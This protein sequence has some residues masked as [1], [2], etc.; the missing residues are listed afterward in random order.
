M[1]NCIT[2][3]KMCLCVC[4]F[5][6]DPRTQPLPV[7]P[8]FPSSYPSPLPS[9]LTYRRWWG[10]DGIQ[11]E[12]NLEMSPV[13][14]LSN[15]LPK[16]SFF[17]LTF[18]SVCG[19]TCTRLPYTHTLNSHIQNNTRSFIGFNRSNCYNGFNSY[20]KFRRSLSSFLGMIT[21]PWSGMWRREWDIET[22]F[23]LR[24]MDYLPDSPKHL[25]QDRRAHYVQFR[26]SRKSGHLEGSVQFMWDGLSTK[27][28]LTGLARA[29]WAI[30]EKEIWLGSREPFRPT[31]RLAI[32]YYVIMNKK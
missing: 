20:N 5:I 19:T 15:S 23:R 4:H 1:K 8:F 16:N 32:L 9:D 25:K 28:E 13:W 2:H 17:R 14:S 6:H 29:Q 27:G 21:S 10:R 30:D 12:V 3:P 26:R 22:S 31:T 7:L 11:T 18:V 24:I